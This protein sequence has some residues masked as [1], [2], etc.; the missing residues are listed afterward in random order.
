[1]S[2]SIIKKSLQKKKN[3]MT[4]KNRTTRN[5]GKIIKFNMKGG[6]PTEES[7]TE[8]ITW[9]GHTTSISAVA[10]HPSGIYL[11]TGSDDNLV[12]L[13]IMPSDASPL[14]RCV[15]TLEGHTNFVSC[16]AFHLSGE[17]LAT[18]SKD[19]KIKLWFLK[20]D[21]TPSICVST[22]EEHSAYVKC[23]AWHP[24]KLILASGSGDK[25]VKLWEL[26]SSYTIGT[27]VANLHD[28]NVVAFD[29]L[30]YY[31]ASGGGHTFKLWVLN[32]E[33]TNA[34]L[35]TTVVED[36]FGFI[37]L[38]AFHPDG[39]YVATA[40]R[41]ESISFVR[42][43]R[44]NRDN[45]E[46]SKIA[47]LRGHYE[48]INTLSF[49]SVA[50]ILATGSKEG[51]SKFW[52]FNHDF[53]EIK[54][55]ATLKGHT[56]SIMSIGFHPY[57]PYFVSGSAD[58]T[59]KLWKCDILKTPYKHIISSLI[60]PET[61]QPSI[62]LG[63]YIYHI[64]G[65][66]DYIDG[67]KTYKFVYIKPYTYDISTGI[68]K[69]IIRTWDMSDRKQLLEYRIDE[70]IIFTVY[71]SHSHMGF[72]R[73]MSKEDQ[74]FG[75][76]HDYVQSSI[77]NFRLGAFILNEINNPSLKVYQLYETPYFPQINEYNYQSFNKY[78]ELHDVIREDW[79]L[80]DTSRVVNRFGIGVL[81]R[82][83][84]CGRLTDVTE[85][86]LRATSLEL[87][88]EY[89]NCVSIE[90]VCNHSFITDYYNITGKIFKLVLQSYLSENIEIFLY[91][92]TIV[93][94]KSNIN[95][96]GTIPIFIKNI[97]KDDP[98]DITLMGTY[99]N[100]IYGY[101]AYICKVIEY[102]DQIIQ[103]IKDRFPEVNQNYRYIGRIYNNLYPTEH[104]NR[105]LEHQ[106]QP[107]MGGRNLSK[108]NKKKYS[109]Y[110]SKYF[111]N[112]T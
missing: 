43:W 4:R 84:I 59:I 93:I 11:A 100:Y 62:Q 31:L 39:N 111:L 67:D 20:F 103:E 44:I 54:C 81:N 104:L 47:T 99:G 102:E 23:V 89:P 91:S 65:Q 34:T 73:F 98:E 46:V 80:M 2:F 57:E 74:G 112:Y 16:L 106:G 53:S 86:Y 56:R 14:P 27:C 5:I 94:P 64:I 9:E 26:N 18:G 45:S 85:A 50:P 12:K 52:Q 68:V 92:Y 41:T 87:K 90:F 35:T 61:L 38:I 13:W 107:K 32:S 40:F 69:E 19:N 10:F 66:K 109:I 21:G 75:K 25:T 78:G 17:Y 1:M 30:G 48:I 60:T 55:V 97:N 95:E 63:K 79:H 15:S 105:F 71:M 37:N 51:S 22:L 83:Q 8:Q 82:P 101:G 72:C 28:V 108:T 77:I 58:K 76:G 7:C 96:N 88:S 24:S 36:A 42:I 6:Q 110:R 29:K 70:P 49:H 33:G 3:H